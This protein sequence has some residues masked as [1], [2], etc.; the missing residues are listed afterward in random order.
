MGVLQTMDGQ[1]DRMDEE[2]VGDKAR[3]EHRDWGVADPRVRCVSFGLS[4]T[5]L[6]APDALLHSDVHRVRPW[7]PR[8]CRRGLRAQRL[9]HC[10]QLLSASQTLVCA[11]LS[12]QVHIT[13]L[14]GASRSVHLHSP[15][16]SDSCC[17][18]ADALWVCVIYNSLF[19]YLQCEKKGVGLKTDSQQ[20]T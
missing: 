7:S 13:A 16:R 17:V 14:K 12:R 6:H 10:G 5:L 9:V 19:I 20:A 8:D 2:D 11:T 3:C 4:H 1:G 15:T 18:E